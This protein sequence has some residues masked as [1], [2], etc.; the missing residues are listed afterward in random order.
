MKNPRYIVVAVIF[1]FHISLQ[2]QIVKSRLNLEIR[3]VIT[4]LGQT[5]NERL[6]LQSLSVNQS[7]VPLPIDNSL[8][9][10]GEWF[11]SYQVG[12]KTSQEFNNFNLKRGYITIKKTLSRHIIGRITPDISVDREGDGEGDIEL[13][14]KYCYINFLWPTIGIFNS[15]Q[16]E[17]GLVHRPWLD[18]EEHINRYRVQGTM[19]LE[20]NG[21]FDSGDYGVTFMTLFGE[22]LNEEY[23][24]QVNKSYPGKFGS[25]AIGIYNGGGYHSIEKNQNKTLEW[26][27]TIRPIPGFIPGFQMSYLGAYGK[28]NQAFAPD[29][30]LHDGFFSFESASLVITTQYFKGTGN[31]KGTFLNS[32]QNSIEHQGY[33]CFGELKF[34][35]WNLIGR[36][37][38]YKTL[39]SPETLRQ[40]RYI[41]GIAYN[42]AGGTKILMDYEIVKSQN[43]TKSS[44][45]VLELALEVRY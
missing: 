4:V 1:I 37:D 7:A 36:Y 15:P 19:F 38:F 30:V 43:A 31:S 39:I 42:L 35:K 28:G 23:Q 14:L 29:W 16:L 18:F 10:S 25:L 45:T 34:Y 13:R 40:N 12:K 26:R 33:S 2:I 20:R 22:N 9:I 32:S 17:F 3:P 5:P 27:V 21:V 41:S 11:L 44:D 8:S 6:P 24:T